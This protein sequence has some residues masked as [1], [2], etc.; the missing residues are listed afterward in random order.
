[1]F[2]MT[3]AAFADTD[4]TVTV[5]AG[6]T[7]VTISLA[8]T[9]GKGALAGVQF[10]IEYTPGLEF[11]KFETQPGI[12]AT[13]TPAIEKNGKTYIGFY[14]GSNTFVPV[15][16]TLLLGYLAF[17]YTGE[18][19]QTIEITELKLVRLIDSDTTESEA[20]SETYTI[21]IVRGSG[22]TPP[23]DGGTPPGDSGNP[24][25]DG[26]PTGGGAPLVQIGDTDI[27]LADIGAV[28]IYAPFINGYPDGT[29][30]PQGQLTRAELAQIVFNLYEAGQGQ[31]YSAS[32][33]DVTIAHWAYKA[34]AYCQE[35][36][37]MLG[38]PDGSFKPGQAITRAELSTAFTRIKELAS[39]TQHPFTDVG[40]HWAK[41]SICAMYAAGNIA[42]YPDGT[43]RPD[44][45]V[46]RA[47][48]AT[49]ICRAE[50]RD[51]ELYDTYKTF[52]DL[53]ESFWAYGSLMNAANGYNYNT[54]P[55]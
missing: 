49:M 33:T 31:N 13:L 34:I 17:A 30:K 15:E 54:I 2:S 46:T 39:E 20:F 40:D 32:Y 51:V 19:T 16:N 42:G 27:P 5:A 55:Q 8:C 6:A 36:G 1:M 35:S 3:Q 52:T 25:G 45:S 11:E 28:I 10:A 9:T 7:E 26:N 29:V 22:G 47:E 12:S 37:S 50:G 43:F 4:N 44:N 53:Y 18:E 41:A 48:A 23:D 14:A 38:Y 24:P 21:T